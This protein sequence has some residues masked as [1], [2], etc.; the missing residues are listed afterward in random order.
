MSC[1]TQ[2]PGRT[3]TW[4]CLPS[5]LREPW[6]MEQSLHPATGS[7][8]PRRGHMPLVTPSWGRLLSAQEHHT[9]KSGQWSHPAGASHLEHCGYGHKAGVCM[10]MACH[11]LPRPLPSPGVQRGLPRVTSP[12]E[13]V[14]RAQQHCQYISIRAAG[15]Q[16]AAEQLHSF[17]WFLAP[18]DLA[19][20]ALCFRLFISGNTFFCHLL[21]E[22]C[23][24]QSV[25]NF[26]DSSA[27][28]VRGGESKGMAAALA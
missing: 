12:T 19:L 26:T 10:L 14:K 3:C 17:S 16:E 24:L 6:L 27:C 28:C 15:K 7:R 8:S 23:K 11:V 25:E 2:W 21:Q 18:A 13:G 9:V 1:S 20:V 5:A 4:P 22:M